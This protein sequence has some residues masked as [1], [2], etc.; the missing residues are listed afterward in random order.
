MTFQRKITIGVGLF[1]GMAALW[2]T[3][4]IVSYL[5]DEP[6]RDAIGFLKE[7]K[8]LRACEALLP[9]ATEGH[10]QAQL[11][12]GRLYAQG[13]GVQE[14]EAV[15][16]MWFRRAECRCD[17]PGQAEFDV[18]LELLEETSPD[19]NSALQW[20]LRAAEAGH[21]RA[22]DFLGNKSQLANAGIK[23]DEP[24]MSY[25]MTAKTRTY[26]SD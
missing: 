23:L 13:H 9:L 20:I 21:P 17:S 15:A 2:S 6:F 4:R 5:E 7:G 8:Y 22:I 16:Q 10:V 25:W 18:G 11:V 19:R 1:V 14:D 24:Y 26:C 3:Y 12:L